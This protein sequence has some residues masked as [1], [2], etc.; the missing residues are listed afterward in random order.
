MLYSEGI[1]GTVLRDTGHKTLFF[2]DSL[3][4]EYCLAMEGRVPLWTPRSSPDPL[5]GPFLDSLD[6]RLCLAWGDP[7]EFARTAN[8]AARCCK[9]SIDS[10]RYLQAMVSI[11]NGLI[12]FRFDN[13]NE[14]I[15]SAL[16]AFASSVFL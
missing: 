5:V 15:R 11:H 13:V 3:L 7:S 8:T 6:T 16:L 1:D 12:N 14:I 10:D 4:V 2:S 9:I